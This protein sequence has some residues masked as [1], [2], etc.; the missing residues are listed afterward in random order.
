MTKTFITVL[1]FLILIP[2]FPFLFAVEGF[3]NGLVNVYKVLHDPRK[4]L[5]TLHRQLWIRKV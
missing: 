2:I 4:A 5:A 1:C 3:A